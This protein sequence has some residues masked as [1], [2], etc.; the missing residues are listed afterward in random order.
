MAPSLSADTA[1]NL[2]RVIDD[3]TS[4]PEPSIPGF[5][6]Q[7]IDRD[8]QVLFNHASGSRGLGH[9]E[10]MTFETTFWLASFTKLITSIA[11]MQ[12]VEQQKLQLDCPETIA[13]FAPELTEVKVLE[14]LPQGGFTLVQPRKAITLRMLMTHTGAV[15]MKWQC[16]S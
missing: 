8:G 13:R 5:I 6:Y 9:T 16:S 1:A 7:A 15:N 2:R 10:P 4:G 12:L 3:K 14:R 11:C